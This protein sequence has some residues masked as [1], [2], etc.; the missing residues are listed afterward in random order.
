[1]RFRRFSIFSC[2]A[3]WLGLGILIFYFVPFRVILF[4]AAVTLLFCGVRSLLKC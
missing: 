2:F 1:M 3:L 4:F